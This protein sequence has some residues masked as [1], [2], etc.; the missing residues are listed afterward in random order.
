MRK[1]LR[2][3]SRLA[4]GFDNAEF[5]FAQ[6]SREDAHAGVPVVTLGFLSLAGSTG[7]MPL[8]L[9]ELIL[10][11]RKKSR[12]LHAFLDLLNR[13]FWEL[14]YMRQCRGGNA[15]HVLR[16]RHSLVR[17]GR[18]TRAFAGVGGGSLSLPPDA[19][20]YLP[21]LFTHCLAA[22]D[23]AGDE[24]QT[25]R[26]ISE[27]L[28]QPVHLEKHIPARLPVT[29]RLALLLG[30][31]RERGD[32]KSRH[33]VLGDRAW[34]ACG[35]KVTM[36]IDTGGSISDMLPLAQ[37]ATLRRLTRLLRVLHSNNLPPIRL[38]LRNQH[39][40]IAVLGRGALLGWGVSLK[41][42]R[43]ASQLVEVS[44]QAMERFIQLPEEN[45]P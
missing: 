36:M 18:L 39:A 28:G 27:I 14:L 43:P 29:S 8:A 32:Q 22:G 9:T 12:A 33:S 10:H 24:A 25:S 38:L 40:A 31:S 19:G 44:H 42:V 7:A 2:L 23:G 1:S 37:G 45:F 11:N 26:L 16:D 34:V 6:V 30:A 35:L 17:Q 4:L 5:E 21:A 15:I 41:S 20:R 13:R 3:Q